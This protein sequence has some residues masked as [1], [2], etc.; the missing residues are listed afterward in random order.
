MGDT[1]MRASEE[2]AIEKLGGNLSDAWKE[3]GSEKGTKFTWDSRAN[4]WN[5]AGF[6]FTCRF[7][8]VFTRGLQTRSLAL[9]A[10]T[11]VP[12]SAADHYLSDHFG[13]VADFD[14]PLSR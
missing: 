2:S 5:E 1:N 6:P 3:N 4:P 11:P 10:N 9:I 12:N 14:H 8:R 7:D 13:L